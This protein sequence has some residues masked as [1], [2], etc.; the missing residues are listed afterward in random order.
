M[1]KQ[2]E[3]KEKQNYRTSPRTCSNCV[4]YESKIVIKT[5]DSWRGKEEWEEERGMKCSLGGF[6]VKKMAVCDLHANK[7]S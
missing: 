6:A 2:S 1:S 3:A 7:Q 5:Y 4:H